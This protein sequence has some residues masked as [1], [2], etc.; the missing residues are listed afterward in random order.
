MKNTMK[1]SIAENT[2][3][4]TIA[5]FLFLILV[6]AG[7]AFAWPW[8]FVGLNV[9]SP[10]AQL[11]VGGDAVIRTNLYAGNVYATSMSGGSGFYHGTASTNRAWFLSAFPLSSTK[12]V[13]MGFTSGTESGALW[14]GTNYMTVGNPYSTNISL[15]MTVIN[16]P[17]TGIVY[18]IGFG[19]SPTSAVVVTWTNVYSP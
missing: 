10:T 9:T 19:T 16:V 2:M 15:T 8:G 13:G 7:S 4:N 5:V 3:K 11:D 14:V 18:R 12:K 1:N 6:F 17:V